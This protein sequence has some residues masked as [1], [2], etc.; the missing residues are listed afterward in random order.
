[1]LAAAVLFSLIASFAPAGVEAQESYLRSLT[2]DAIDELIAS[3]RPD[4]PAELTIA[5]RPITV[6][7]ANVLNRAPADRAA[8]AAEVLSRLSADGRRVAVSSREL[9]SATVISA[10]DRDVLALV[11]LDADQLIGETVAAKAAA[12]VQRLQQALD[13]ISE[14]QRP[15]VLVWGLTQ[16]VL[17]TVAFAAIIVM[18][19]RAN[20]SA[21]E[22]A[23]RSTERRL[24]RHA[25]GGEI[26]REMRLIHYVRR[27]IGVS[28]AIIGVSV[29]YLWLTFVLRRFPYTRPWGESLRTLLLARLSTFAQNA[30]A[31][32]PDLFT[33]ALIVILTRFAVRV[34]QLV[35]AAVEQERMAI[36]WI[37]PETAATT[38]KL[39][40]GLLWLFALVV[41]YPYLPG[42]ET[43]A[44]KGISVFLGL[45]VTLGSSGLV[46]QV[47]SGFTLTYS[48]AL[49]TGDFVRVG[50]VEGTV[51]YLGTLSTKIETP[52]REE[53]T[54][55]NAVLVSQEVT[56]YSRNAATGVFATTELTIGYDAPWRK[57]EAL[58]LRAAGV[59][60]GVRREP[61]PFVLQKSLEDF[62]VRYAL[63]VSLDDAARRGPILDEL[64]ANIQ[65][66]FNE[67]GVQ[68]MSPNYEADP[69]EP[70]LVPKARWY[71]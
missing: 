16:A 36:V 15:R 37:Y 6:L 44:F 26:V 1:M 38:R 39:I 51:R 70:K 9:G 68:I 27:S 49:R 14:A 65:D 17:A 34:V 55:P 4:T 30:L 10:G 50:D 54:I 25:M 66:A 46:N 8:A 67:E 22:A 63:M 19:G 18:L 61:A 33:I 60:D 28:L 71:T 7:R 64:H 3:T 43:E 29:G 13:E 12:T 59:T 52:R 2:P 40:T 48:R 57:V 20:R 41:A 23:S 56:N 35:F 69:G 5:N 42:S 32:L 21:S 11:P 62:Y 47:M 45:M 24:T 53:V 58:L 31:A